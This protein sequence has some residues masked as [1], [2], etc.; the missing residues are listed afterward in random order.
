M[1]TRFLGLLA[2]AIVALG[3]AA[4]QAEAIV[5]Y[6]FTGSCSFGCTGQA[7]AVLILDDTYVPG[8]QVVAADFIAISYSSDAG[9]Y[10]IPPDAGLELI[11]GPAVLPAVAGEATIGLDF[12]DAGR[13][14]QTA[15]AG[16]WASL[17][18]SLGIDHGGT[19]YEWVL[20]QLPAP[21][22][23]SLLALGLVG[24]AIAGRRRKQAA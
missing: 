13:I 16:V 19:E 9:S 6:D 11:F 3:M 20:R 2:A 4:P 23:L 7:T 5:I 24:L 21:G 22:P 18:V 12:T 15:G 8:T 17:F 1:K 10:Q 14:F